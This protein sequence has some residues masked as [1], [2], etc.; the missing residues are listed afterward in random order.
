MTVLRKALVLS[1][2]AMP[3]AILVTT[4]ARSWVVVRR[5]PAVWVAPR[6][7]VVAYGAPVYPYA[8]MAYRPVYPGIPPVAGYAYAPR[9]YGGYYGGGIRPAVVY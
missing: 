5:R 2:V 8:G 9:Y 6:P 4:E 1:L 3:L 7:P